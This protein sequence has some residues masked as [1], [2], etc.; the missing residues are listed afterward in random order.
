MSNELDEPISSDKDYTTEAGGIFDVPVNLQSQP[1]TQV[2]YAVS[3]VDGTE[4]VVEELF[5]MRFTRDLAL[6]PRS[7]RIRGLEDD[8][9]LYS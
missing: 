8:D 5:V 4:V 7:M 9:R 3:I 1:L 6:V 2:M